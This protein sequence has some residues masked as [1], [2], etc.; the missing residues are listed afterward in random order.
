[1][2]NR[3]RQKLKCAQNGIPSFSSWG[4][5]LSIPVIFFYSPMLSETSK[6]L[7]YKLIHTLQIWVMEKM[8]S[9]VAQTFELYYPHSLHRVLDL[10]WNE[11]RVFKWI[12]TRH[13][14]DDTHVARALNLSKNHWI[15]T[16][17]QWGMRSS[18]GQAECGQKWTEMGRM[19]SYRTQAL[20]VP[21]S[22]GPW[23]GDPSCWVSRPK[24]HR[25]ASLIPLKSI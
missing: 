24:E 5:W 4:A 10:N 16:R 12:A 8:Q 7:Y 21:G 17:R 22:D 15:G 23:V 18:K 9:G 20:P 19:Q 13:H 3:T 14:P 11:D 2:Y 6:C 25:V 1:M